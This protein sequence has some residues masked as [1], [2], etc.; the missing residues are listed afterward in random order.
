ML[1]RLELLDSWR[2]A[3][4]TF[5]SG[6]QAATFRGVVVDYDGTLSN[7]RF[8]SLS[9]DISR[10]LVRLLNASIPLA[11]ATGRGKSARKVLREVIPP[12][13]W[14]RVVVGY[15]NGGD[16]GLLSADKP[17]PTQRA[18]AALS[19]IAAALQTNPLLAT[20]AGLEFRIPQLT[21]Q[22]KRQELADDVWA[23]VNETVQ[24]LQTPGTLVL[25][26][27]HSIDVL[28][29]QADKRAVVRRLQRLADAVDA[30]VLCIGDKG[31]FPGNDFFL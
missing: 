29:P 31:R 7:D 25:R 8:G 14:D 27:S 4:R 21:I 16:I 2:R 17:D 15:Y 12:R 24:V 28:G 5:T 1:S 23:I 22:P 6:L 3:Y 9:S 11:V 20:L 30:P 26:S 10:E 18:G 19:E 13:H